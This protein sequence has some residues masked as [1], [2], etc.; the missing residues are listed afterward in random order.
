MFSIWIRNDYMYIIWW[1][2][3]LQNNPI[4]MAGHEKLIKPCGQI[5]SPPDYFDL[6][7]NRRSES[8]SLWTELLLFLPFKPS[9]TKE[10]QK[11]TANLH[12]WHMEDILVMEIS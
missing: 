8:T 11:S 2:F 4:T 9:N 3:V 6:F 7:K 5:K 12:G 1:I 10:S